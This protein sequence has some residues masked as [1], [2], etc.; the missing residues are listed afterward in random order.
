MGAAYSSLGRTKIVYANSLVPLG[1]LPAKENKC[2]RC[3]PYLRPNKKI[4]VFR[5]TVLEI[6]GR[7]GHIFFLK[8]N[9][10]I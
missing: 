9:R 1:E 3:L 4:S 7:V 8:K 10:I 2:P 6:L 5:V